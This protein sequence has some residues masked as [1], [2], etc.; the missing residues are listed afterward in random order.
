MSPTLLLLRLLLLPPPLHLLPR[1]HRPHR[2][3]LLPPLPQPHFP[4]PI[5][6]RFPP[7]CHRLPHPLPPQHHR[8]LPLL[9]PHPLPLPPWRRRRKYRFAVR[10][11]SS[12]PAARSRLLAPARRDSSEAEGDCRGSRIWPEEA[13]AR[14][15]S[16]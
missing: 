12:F 4:L 15:R 2:P 16:R 13:S 14:S 11:V 7:L 10:A 1:R 5:P 6:A 9:P 3:L 8:S